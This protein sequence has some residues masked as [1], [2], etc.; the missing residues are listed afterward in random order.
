MNAILFI[1]II[2]FWAKLQEEA[3]RRK[4]N[5]KKVQKNFANQK[6]SNTFAL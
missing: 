2:Y 1:A 5:E 3:D 4:K 6:K